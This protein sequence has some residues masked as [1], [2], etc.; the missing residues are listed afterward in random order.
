MGFPHTPFLTVITVIANLTV[1]STTS[2]FPAHKNLKKAS[3]SLPPAGGKKFKSFFTATCAWG[4]IPLRLPVWNFEPRAQNYARSR[5]RA[6]CRKN[7]EGFSTVSTESVYTGP[8]IRSPCRCVNII[9]TADYC[10]FVGNHW[11][12]PQALIFGTPP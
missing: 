10:L 2:V 9:Y 7:P 6:F 3:Q 5:L 8:V 11:F 4:K 1:L 12:F